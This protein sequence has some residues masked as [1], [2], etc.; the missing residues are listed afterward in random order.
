MCKVWF[1]DIRS[2]WNRV[3][4]EWDFVL[5]GDMAAH[6][7][8]GPV[9]KYLCLGLWEW[10]LSAKKKGRRIAVFVN[11]RFCNTGHI[12]M[13]ECIQLPTA[14]GTSAFAHLFLSFLLLYVF[15]FSPSLGYVKPLQ[16]PCLF[17]IGSLG[18]QIELFYAS[19]ICLV[20][21]F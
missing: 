3:L 10:T 6:G 9:P 4:I 8:P 14:T 16:E 19:S 13:R 18:L 1:S 17:L 2:L 11:K 5:H 15:W 7:L 21:V 20:T 12:I